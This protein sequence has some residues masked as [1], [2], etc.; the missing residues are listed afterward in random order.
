MVNLLCVFYYNKNNWEKKIIANT[1]MECLL[2]GRQ[3]SKLTTKNPSNYLLRLT[4]AHNNPMKQVLSFIPV[5]Q[6]LG[7]GEVNNFPWSRS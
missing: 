7:L 4:I 5:S 6:T 1:P 3:W 2:C